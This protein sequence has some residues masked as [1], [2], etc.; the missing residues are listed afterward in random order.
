M[1]TGGLFLGIESAIELIP[2]VR[3][4]LSDTLRMREMSSEHMY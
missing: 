2:H 4:K 3:K 1:T